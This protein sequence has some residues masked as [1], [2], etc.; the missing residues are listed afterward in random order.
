MQKPL[1]IILINFIIISCG[2]IERS[3]HQDH[4]FKDSPVGLTED[5]ESSVNFSKTQILLHHHDKRIRSEITDLNQRHNDLFFEALKGQYRS[6]SPQIEMESISPGWVIRTNEFIDEEVLIEALNTDFKDLESV[7]LEIVSPKSRKHLQYISFDQNELKKGKLSFDYKFP[8]GEQAI[9]LGI[10]DFKSNKRQGHLD[11]RAQKLQDSFELLISSPGRL[12]ISYF[13]KD[14]ISVEE[15]L[16]GMNIEHTLNAQGE[17]ISL[18][19]FTNSSLD[20]NLD[21]YP[22]TTGFWKAINMP[23]QSLTYRPKAGESILIKHMSIDQ[24]RERYQVKVEQKFH[25]KGNGASFTI[26]PP[27]GTI[28]WELKNIRMIE[29]IPTIGNQNLKGRY[30]YTSG[31]GPGDFR[32]H[33]EEC[34]FTRKQVTYQEQEIKLDSLGVKAESENLGNKITI[35]DRRPVSFTIQRPSYE[36]TLAVGNVRNN[37]PRKN[38]A[39]DGKGVSFGLKNRSYKHR[40]EVKALLEFSLGLP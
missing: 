28:H 35:Y 24:L 9:E 6:K 2:K 40:Y 18:L 38:T 10:Y 39:Y 34:A 26:T 15:A 17:I 16:K 4:L 31:F 8:D 1:L 11:A 5:K 22:P 29:E 36:K 14:S 23:S 32:M 13:V 27:Q 37:C 19:G 3:S 25:Y 33:I 7:I 20:V 12:P 30:S 21:N